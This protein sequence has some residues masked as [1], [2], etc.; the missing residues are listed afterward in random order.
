MK[1]LSSKLSILLFLLLPT[2]ALA[3]G[4]GVHLD[5]APIDLSD[6]ESL[7]NGAKIFMNYC[8]SC[9]SARFMRYK[10]MADDLGMEESE[11]L[12]NLVFTGAKIHDTMEIAMPADQATQWFGTAPPDLSVISRARGV[13]W[14][15]TYLRGFYVDESRPMGV[16]NIVFKDVGMPHVLEGL[17]G[18][19]YLKE[20]KVNM[21]YGGEKTMESLVVDGSG[22]MTPAEYDKA[23]TDLVNFLAYVGEPIKAY[24]LTLGWYVLGFLLILLI[25]AYRLKKE[26]WKDVH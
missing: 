14:L 6:K 25:P 2:F 1:K 12:E 16:N 11:V 22:S 4:G 17:Q 13:D 5:S 9:H 23:V 10:R 7:K 3:S 20:E 26:Y 18:K 19:Q 8:L 21:A 15:Y 24:R